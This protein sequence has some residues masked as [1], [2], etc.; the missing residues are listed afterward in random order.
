MFFDIVG[1]ISEDVESYVIKYFRNYE[2]LRFG[3]V[4]IE[5]LKYD[6]QL[7][8]LIVN[9]LNIVL[10]CFVCEEIKGVFFLN[11][12]K[13]YGNF[14]LCVLRRDF[15]KKNKNVFLDFIEMCLD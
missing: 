1:Y 6:G 2:D 4:L 9:L 8:E 15:V 5:K 14:V 12:M 3:N 10:L 11:K 7:K 13:L